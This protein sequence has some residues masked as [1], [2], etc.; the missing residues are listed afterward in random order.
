VAKALIDAK[1]LKRE[2]REREMP[3]TGQV[4]IHPPTP[5]VEEVQRQ[6]ANMVLDRQ[7]KEAEQKMK[8]QEPVKTRE[9][10]DVFPEH[11]EGAPVHRRPLGDERFRWPTLPPETQR[12]VETPRTPRFLD[13]TCPSC[14]AGVV[15]RWSLQ[16]SNCGA[17]FDCWVCEACGGQVDPEY[18]RCTGCGTEYRFK[19]PGA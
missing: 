12:V 5:S 17:Q 4:T 8:P 2:E 14:N 15:D 1:K 3:F 7:R 10:M 9:P 6:M 11:E 19:P 13:D 18:L 16:C